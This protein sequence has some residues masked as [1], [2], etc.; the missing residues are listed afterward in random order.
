MENWLEGLWII[1]GIKVERIAIRNPV[2][3][4]KTVGIASFRARR[5]EVIEIK[6]LYKLAE[7]DKNWIPKILYMR[8]DKVL[9]FP[10]QF[11]KGDGRTE[12]CMTPLADYEERCLY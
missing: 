1:K 12:L 7:T 9:T 3:H 8:S 11:A 5:S 6:V 4:D 10:R 2:W